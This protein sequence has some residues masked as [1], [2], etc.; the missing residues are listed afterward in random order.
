[1][2]VPSGSKPK[3]HLTALWRPG[4][5]KAAPFSF[6]GLPPTTSHKRGWQGRERQCQGGKTKG[7]DGG[8]GN[9]DGWWWCRLLSV[10]VRVR[11]ASQAVK[12]AALL[13][14][15]ASSPRLGDRPVY[16]LVVGNE[17]VVDGI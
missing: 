6:L 8:R 11:V 15:W 14:L 2:V 17:R 13:F 10:G 5:D 9:L 16:H 12:V 1:M 7:A 4:K 3:K